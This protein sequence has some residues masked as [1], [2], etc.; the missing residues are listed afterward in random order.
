MST[1]TSVTDS[2]LEAM[3]ATIGVASIDELFAGIPEGLRMRRPLDLPEGLAA[4]EVHERLRALAA[5]NVSADDEVS[6][7]GGGMYD[8]YVPALI[9]TLTSRSEFLSPYSPYQPEVSQG[10]RQVMF[11]YQTAICELS[12][13]DGANASMYDGPSAVVAAAYLAMMANG[14]GEVVVDQHASRFGCLLFRWAD[15]VFCVSSRRDQGLASCH[16]ARS[17]RTRGHEGYWTP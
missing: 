6:F 14:R 11:E 10:G 7:L 12:G 16:R 15:R 13:R 8:H 9:D 4:Q 2:D 1:Y 5:R 17:H 3:L